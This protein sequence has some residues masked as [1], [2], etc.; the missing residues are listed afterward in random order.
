MVANHERDV[1][2]AQRKRI[3]FSK[4][5]HLQDEEG[6]TITIVH[7]ASGQTM[8]VFITDLTRKY[9]VPEGPG[10]DEASCIDEIEGWCLT[11]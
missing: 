5:S 4:I 9:S 3:K 11:S 6:D 8:D 10:N 1:A 7:P 2:Q